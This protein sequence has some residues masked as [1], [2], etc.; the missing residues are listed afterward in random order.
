MVFVALHDSLALADVDA[1]AIVCEQAHA[2]GFEQVEIAQFSSAIDLVDLASS[3]ADVPLE[4][5]VLPYDLLGLSG[6]QAIAEARSAQP[7]LIAIVIDAASTHAI[8]ATRA[9]IDGYLVEPIDLI[10][11]SRILGR[12]FATL[13]RR[14]DTS[15]LL[16]TRTGPVLIALDDIVYCETDGHNQRIHL[17]DRRALSGRYSSLALFDIL[18]CDKRFFKVGSSYIVNLHEVRR[19]HTPSGDLALS[20][21]AGIPVPQR[22]RKS[23]EE[24]L[25]AQ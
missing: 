7:D 22:L 3:K 11:F 15:V 13:R 24:A 5:A 18:A 8:E 2:A 14:H 21:G 17:K 20:D 16:V 23:L 25:L 19:L 10:E 12:A 9:G 6:I 4:L 1:R